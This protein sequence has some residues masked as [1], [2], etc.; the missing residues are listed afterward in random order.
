MRVLV[1]AML[2]S[3]CLLATTVVHAQQ[4]RFTGQTHANAQ[5]I[6]D[7]MQTVA[8][9]GRGRYHCAAPDLVE[10]Q[11]APPDFAVERWQSM[12]RAASIT[13]ER[14]N[15]SL[16]G[17]V[18]PFAIGYWPSPDG[19]FLFAITEWPAN[20]AQVNA[21]HKTVFADAEPPA[22]IEALRSAADGGDAVAQLK[23]GDAYLA[24]HGVPRDAEQAMQWFRKSAGIGNT[25]AINNIGMMYEH[26]FGVTQ[27]FAEA[28]KW[29]RRAA[30][31]DNAIAQMN[32]GTLYVTGRGVAQ[33][34]AQAMAWYRKSA[35][36]GNSNAQYNIGALYFEGYGVQQDYAQALNWFNKSAGDGNPN[37]QRT[38][39]L[40]YEQGLGVAQD[41]G[42]AKEWYTKA[43][44][45][46]DAS[47]KQ[48]L[49]EL[50]GHAN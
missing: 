23:L 44:D 1:R 35:D 19:S 30:E 11:L 27:D 8:M 10:A 28:A 31:Q 17:T 3:V 25:M 48:L 43:A 16:C 24:G 9:L 38:I 2:T 33:D 29:Y 7:V 36:A 18:A 40:M 5:L 13:Y 14:W 34:Y 21:P 4:V 26:G 37:A 49:S 47:A 39:G 22:D 6:H 42:K 32:L 41:H 20:A 45:Q 50:S 12:A 46:G 15:V